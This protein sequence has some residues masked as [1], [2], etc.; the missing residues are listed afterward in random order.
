MT[1][2]ELI[3]SLEAHGVNPR[4]YFAVLAEQE[5]RMVPALKAAPRR[6]FGDLARIREY[7][8]VLRQT[9]LHRAIKLTKAAGESL[10]SNN[11][12]AL[13]LSVRAHF[14]TTA[15]IGYLHY[16]LNSMRQ[17]NITPE[18]M[19]RDIV[20]QLLGTRDSELLSRAGA[21][22]VEAKQ[23]LTMLEYADMSVSQYVLGGR[24]NEHKM[25]M[26]I[27]RWLCEFCHPNFHSNKLA[28]DLDGKEGTF[29]FRHEGAL[30]KDEASILGNLFISA[31]VFVA[32][33]DGIEQL[34]P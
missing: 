24:S 25:L 17:G 1:R 22:G 21:D 16:R 15:S 19:D 30:D 34:L 13:A 4:E 29:V 2:D 8:T 18:I 11:G 3:E 5:T 12:Y 28:F 20:V 10:A 31:P 9:L 6:D 7:S 26:D 33:Y 23:I 32:L 27:Y 14:E